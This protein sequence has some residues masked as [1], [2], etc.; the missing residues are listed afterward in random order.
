MYPVDVALPLV[1]ID[2][3]GHRRPLP[4]HVRDILQSEASQLPHPLI[5]LDTGKPS[6][7]PVISVPTRLRHF[8]P[9]PLTAISKQD[10]RTVVPPPECAGECST[11]LPV[12]LKSPQTAL[13]P[14]AVLQKVRLTG[15]L[16]ELFG[17]FSAPAPPSEKRHKNDGQVPNIVI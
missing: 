7:L 8:A 6:R 11:P 16:G 2:K 3:I 12:H 15:M 13:R 9:N 10:I 5:V 4:H 14:P 17:P 1:I